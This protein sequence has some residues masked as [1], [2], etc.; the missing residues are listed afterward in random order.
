MIIVSSTNP[1]E[2]LARPASD[3]IFRTLSRPCNGWTPITSNNL[4]W[5]SWQRS[6]HFQGIRVTITDDRELGQ[7]LSYGSCRAWKTVA[8]IGK[9]TR[10]STLF[11]DLHESAY[12]KTD[13][14]HGI[15]LG[16]FLARAMKDG[17]RR[18]FCSPWKMLSKLSD[19]GPSSMAYKALAWGAKVGDCPY[20]IV[21]SGW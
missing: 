19:L 12:P 4:F 1:V 14:F 8:N 10:S 13:H 20:R 18:Q 6:N 2:A 9:M 3:T 21:F 11:G 16:K 5:V 17:S 15:W 7:L